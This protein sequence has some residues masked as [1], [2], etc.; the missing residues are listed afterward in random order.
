[1]NIPDT[2]SGD[3]FPRRGNPLFLAMGMALAASLLAG[4]PAALAAAKQPNILV[5][6]ADDMGSADI[7]PYGGEV[8]TPTLDSLANNGLLFTNFHT[9]ASCS[10]TRSMLL[11]GVDN[12]LNGFGTMAG[13]LS[14]PPAAPQVGK[15]G[16][17]G[18]LNNSVVTIANVMQGVG[19]H[20]YMTGKWHMGSK[21]GYRPAQRGFEESYALMGGGFIHYQ[22]DEMAKA[23][24]SEDTVFD[25]RENDVAM[26]KWPADFYSSKNFTDK[27]IE[28]I[29]K[30]QDD[31]KPF[32]G[33][34]AYTAP[35]SPLQA[36]EEY[37]AKYLDKYTAGWNEL[38][39]ARFLKQ[40]EMGLLRAGVKEPPIRG[41]GF[42]PWKDNP[43]D[44]RQIDAKKMAVYAAMID[45]M[46]MS[47]GRVVQHLK[48]IGQYENTIIVFMSDNG[49]E[50]NNLSQVFTP[51]LQGA[52][53]PIDNSA[54]NI[55]AKSSYVSPAPGFALTSDMPSF[56]AKASVAEGGIRNNF[57]VSY[58]GVIPSNRRT[59]AFTSVLDVFPTLISYAQAA[60]PTTYNGNAILPLNGKSMR[61]LWEDRRALVHKADEAVGIEVFGSVNRSMFMGPWKILC[62]G[63]APWGAGKAQP[64]KLFNM[65]HDKPEMHDLSAQYP[66]VL[67]DMVSQFHQY[68]AN[69]GFVAATTGDGACGDAPSTPATAARNKAADAAGPSSAEELLGRPLT[70]EDVFSDDL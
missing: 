31:G 38:R 61:G 17:E 6:V 53:I 11:S 59:A 70:L 47:I 5:I 60:Y 69:V 56:G 66:D 27:M 29:D 62:L 10:P 36:P 16:Y 25:F 4:G 28:Y 39:H 54:A 13:R 21:D 3:S 24:V 22:W 35:H 26:A 58:P 55:G 20:T 7:G 57:I 1:M 52:G 14:G 2:I 12:H 67:S 43:A 34:L 45:Y 41:A 64:W 37:V 33:Y 30:N 49:P 19:Y 9:N 68:Q 46:D 40:K 15:P 8:S 48:D 50:A 42:T 44:Q 63:D 65:K 32:F 51:V 18:Y 23:P